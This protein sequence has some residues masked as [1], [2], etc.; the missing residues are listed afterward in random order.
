[1]YSTPLLK[2]T[3]LDCMIAI[4]QPLNSY[5]NILFNLKYINLPRLWTCTHLIRML[6]LQS[7]L[8]VLLFKIGTNMGVYS[9]IVPFFSKTKKH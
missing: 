3:S 5:M 4:T 7:W 2:H 6:T 1:M 8:D 9:I